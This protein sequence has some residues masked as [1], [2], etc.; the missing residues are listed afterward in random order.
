M[1]NDQMTDERSLGLLKPFD[2][3]KKVQASIQGSKCLAREV[4]ESWGKPDGD[5]KRFA[6]E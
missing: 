6:I 3:I 2:L 5:L 4:D 1:P